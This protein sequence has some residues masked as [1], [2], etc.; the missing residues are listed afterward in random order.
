MMKVKNNDF[1]INIYL[2]EKIEGIFLSFCYS[3]PNFAF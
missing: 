1:Q 3:D 2:I